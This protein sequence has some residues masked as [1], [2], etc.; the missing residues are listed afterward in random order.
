MMLVAALVLAQQPKTLTFSHPCASAATVLEA[1]GKELGT[2]MRPTGSV[3]RDYLM[4]RFDQVPVDEAL[5]RMATVANATWTVSNGVRYLGRTKQQEDAGPLQLQAML[6]KSVAEYITKDALKV[7]SWTASRAMGLMR[8]SIGPDGTIDRTRGAAVANE[9]GPCRELLDEFLRTVGAKKLAAIPEGKDT[10][11][12][13][14]PGKGE[15]KIPP[16]LRTKAELFAKN[17][18]TFGAAM[19]SAGVQLLGDFDLPGE[20]RLAGSQG[21]S[22]DSICFRLRRHS[23]SLSAY[24]SPNGQNP[25][26][27]AQVSVQAGRVSP[28]DPV[29]FEIEGVFRP[30]EV[31]RTVSQRLRENLNGKGTR[32]DDSTEVGKAIIKWFE[33]GLAPEPITVFHTDVIADIAERSNKNVVGVYRNFHGTFVEFN[34][35]EETAYTDVLVELM[36]NGLVVDGDWLV[37]PAPT[38]LSKTAPIKSSDLAKFTLSVYRTGWPTIDALAELAAGCEDGSSFQSARQFSGVLQP[39]QYGFNWM[40][41]E[42]ERMA[43]TLYFSLPSS[44]KRQ[45]RTDWVNLPFEDLPSGV[46]QALVET[47]D[48]QGFGS[49]RRNIAPDEMWG[50]FTYSGNFVGEPNHSSSELLRSVLQVR[51]EQRQ[52]LASPDKVVGNRHSSSGMLTV[53]QAAQNY[54]GTRDDSERALDYGTLTVFTAERLQLRVKLASGETLYFIYTTESRNSETPYYPIAQ[55]PGEIGAKLRDEVKRLGG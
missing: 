6:E 39:T 37:T 17:V 26:W 20:V 31:V 25:S 5:K 44:A 35:R 32:L 48:A 9:S 54:V 23:S 42:S 14:A 50:G 27:Y 1:L 43:L 29:P 33:D 18:T 19:T 46:R 45:A 10:V 13:W 15:E 40:L 16:V 30:T 34:Q 28:S 36:R 8:E 11:Y 12:R 4:L 52:L 7:T 41:R 21:L 38:I 51:V 24:V 49:T 53:E 55:L 3:M 2:P 47:F 22:A